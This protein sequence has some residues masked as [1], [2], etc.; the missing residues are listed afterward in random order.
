MSELDEPAFN[1]NKIRVKPTATKTAASSSIIGEG[2]YGCVYRPALRCADV[3]DIDYTGTVTK[4][5]SREDAEDELREFKTIDDLDPEKKFHVGK[6][7]I[8]RPR[9][10]DQDI[11][12]T[13]NPLKNSRSKD[14]RLLVMPDGGMDL[15]KFFESG[16]YKPYFQKFGE[17]GLDHFLQAAEA[18]L[19]GLA[20]MQHN[21][22]CHHDIKTQN[23]V[24][25]TDP[26]TGKI[27]LKLID[28]GMMNTFDEIKM[29]ST[30][31]VNRLGTYWFNFPLTC[32]IINQKMYTSARAFTNSEGFLLIEMNDPRANEATNYFSRVVGQNPREVKREYT[33]WFMARGPDTATYDNFLNYAVR[34]IDIFG[35]G[36]ALLESMYTMRPIF[37]KYKAGNKFKNFYDFFLRM[38]RYNSPINVDEYITDYK[39]LLQMKYQKQVGGFDPYADPTDA[40]GEPLRWT[41][42]GGR[43]RRRRT[44]AKKSCARTRTRRRK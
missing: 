39:A 31:N 11:F 2:S 37:L 33:E 24:I 7:L 38:T 30:A 18:L 34:K 36:F 17:A 8:C 29:F 23:V 10:M 22:L 42:T 20:V 44:R 28:F 5:L 3:S 27:Q 15:A 1:T 4:I 12:K 19:N 25:S 32:G 6:P 13:C 26:A 21:G 35:M 43:K 41:R 16:A 9:D 14:Y 40:N